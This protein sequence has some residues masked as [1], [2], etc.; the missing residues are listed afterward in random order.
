MTYLAREAEQALIPRSP[1][2]NSL[3]YPPWLQ[4]EPVNPG[5][6]SLTEVITVL[7]SILYSGR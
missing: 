3:S 2:I 5:Q 7:I 6:Q 4:S 1:L